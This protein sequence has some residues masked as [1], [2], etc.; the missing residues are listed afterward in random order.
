MVGFPGSGKSHFPAHHAALSKYDVINRDSLGSWQKCASALQTA[1]NK[2]LSVII[3]NTNPSCYRP[4]SSSC[5]PEIF[6]VSGAWFG[7]Q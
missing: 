7:L 5:V 1:L 6:S 4:G 2:G 3:D